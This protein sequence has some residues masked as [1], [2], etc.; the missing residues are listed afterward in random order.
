VFREAKLYDI[1][2]TKP[3]EGENATQPTGGSTLGG[4]TGGNTGGSGSGDDDVTYD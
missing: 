1:D 2:S 3:T 4:N